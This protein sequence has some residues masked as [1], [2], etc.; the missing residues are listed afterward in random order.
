MKKLLKVFILVTIISGL[1]LTGCAPAVQTTTPTATVVNAPTSTT[2]STTA[3]STDKLVIYAP[4]STS[5]IPVI[6]AASKLKNVELTL[7]TNQSQANTLFL[8]GDVSILVTGLSVGVDLFK[9]GAPVQMTNSFVSGLSYL[10]TYGKKVNSWA[11]LKGQQIYLPFAGSPIE[12]A[13][14]YLAE[15]AGLKYG[16]DL[17]PVYSPFD[18]SV[19]LLKEGKATAVVLPEPYVTLVE[20]QP[21]VNISLSYFDEWNKAAGNKQGYPQVGSFVNSTWAKTHTAEITEFNQALGEAITSVENDPATAVKSVSSYYKLTP[22]LL[23]KSLSRTRFNL[24]VGQ[25][26]QES[27]ANYYQTIGKPLDEKYTDFYFLS[28]K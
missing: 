27:I 2:E 23:L 16:T 28:A 5:S 12:E 3:A 7:Y 9:N 21:N 10:V 11:D 20:G 17:T 26:M 22:E 13:T 8:R 4:A 15:Q 24:T 6:L 18:S 14:T 1:L 19:V 25:E